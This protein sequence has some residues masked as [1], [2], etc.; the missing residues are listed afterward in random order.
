[1]MLLQVPLL[2]MFSVTVISIN[3]MG[4]AVQAQEIEKVDKY[5]P[6][7]HLL[8][9]WQCHC[10]QRHRGRATR[11]QRRLLDRSASQLSRRR[12]LLPSHP[13]LLP[14]PQPQ[15]HGAL[16]LGSGSVCLIENP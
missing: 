14:L 4:A 16:G 6:S 5:I 1:M 9:R 3:R 8:R 11:L 2:L 7:R 12:H 15:P 13:H 10:R